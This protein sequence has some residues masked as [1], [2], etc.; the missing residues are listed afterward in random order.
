MERCEK[1]R[2]KFD[3]WEAQNEFESG[4]YTPFPVCYDQFGRSLCGACAIE[5]FNAGNYYEI[6]ECCGKRFNPDS[7]VFSF[8]AQVSHRVS[9][10]MMYEFGVHCADCA[11]SK[12][13]N[14]LED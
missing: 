14:S 3:R 11:A 7:E 4:I 9:D 1:C 8:E 2:K 13:L 10:A 5:E 12:L 6:C